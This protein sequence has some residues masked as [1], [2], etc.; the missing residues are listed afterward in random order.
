MAKAR[1]SENHSLFGA[2]TTEMDR[3]NNIP[4]IEFAMIFFHRRSTL[5]LA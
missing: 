4:D 5:S 3:R 2:L 1:G